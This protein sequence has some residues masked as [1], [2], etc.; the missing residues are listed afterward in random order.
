MTD[1][2]LSAVMCLTLWGLPIL[3]SIKRDTEL[4]W[5]VLTLNFPM[6]CLAVTVHWRVE[7]PPGKIVV[8]LPCACLCYAI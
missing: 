6:Q 1:K 5:I 2:P 4:F 7:Q 8:F 3:D